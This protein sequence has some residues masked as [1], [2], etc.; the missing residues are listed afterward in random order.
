MTLDFDGDS[1]RVVIEVEPNCAG[2]TG[3]AWE[4]SVSCPE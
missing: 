1:S 2:G 3:T 4:L